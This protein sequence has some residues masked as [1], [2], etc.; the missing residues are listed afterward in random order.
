MFF[1]LYLFILSC[2]RGRC[3]FSRVEAHQ[4]TL[5]DDSLRLPSAKEL[6]AVNLTTTFHVLNRAR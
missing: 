4:S 1:S 3:N 6:S 5:R 2:T